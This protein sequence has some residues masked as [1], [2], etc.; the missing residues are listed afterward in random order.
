MGLIDESG[1]FG[2]FV[3]PNAVSIFDAAPQVAPSGGGGGAIFGPSAPIAA[4]PRTQIDGNDGCLEKARGS[5][6]ELREYMNNSS[7]GPLVVDSSRVPS[8]MHWILQRASYMFRQT[9]GSFTDRTLSGIFLCGPSVGFPKESVNTGTGPNLVDQSAR[10][11]RLD[12]PNS[13][14]A[15]SV[16]NDR[17][18]IYIMKG[19]NIYV[20]AGCFVRGLASI[21]SGGTGPGIPGTGY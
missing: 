6:A 7:T 1:F 21:G 20:P 17:D 10:G 4:K 16:S 15:T 2:P 9:S 13:I 5:M 3:G 8:G 11:L 19:G 12:D 14:F 18:E